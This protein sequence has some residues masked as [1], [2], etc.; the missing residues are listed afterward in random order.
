MGQRVISQKIRPP[1][2]C[3]LRERVFADVIKLK[4]LKVRSCWVE[5]LEEKGRRHTGEEAL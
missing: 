3:E 1:R 4:T 5:S 2:T